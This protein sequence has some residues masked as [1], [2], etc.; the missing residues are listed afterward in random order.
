MIRKGSSRLPETMQGLTA[1]AVMQKGPQRINNCDKSRP[2]RTMQ[3]M[4][5][6]HETLQVAKNGGGD[7]LSH[8]ARNSKSKK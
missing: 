8:P 1:N 4:R 2:N 3:K 7:R 6:N 5:G